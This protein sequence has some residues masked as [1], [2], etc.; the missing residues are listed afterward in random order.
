MKI[1]VFH[2][3]T[4]GFITFKNKNDFYKFVSNITDRIPN[5]KMTIQ[6]LAR[7]LPNEEYCTILKGG[8]II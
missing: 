1:K 8:K 3:T 6:E 7:L 5:N 4:N 2:I